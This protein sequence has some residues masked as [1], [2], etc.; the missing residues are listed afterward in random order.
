MSAF[1]AAYS[2]NAIGKKLCYRRSQAA[3][4]AGN[5]LFINLFANSLWLRYCAV[6]IL[7]SKYSMWS[8]DSTDFQNKKGA[9]IFNVGWAATIHQCLILQWKIYQPHIPYNVYKESS[10]PGRSLFQGIE[11]RNKA[12]AFAKMLISF[13]Q[14]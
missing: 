13:F 9:E 1:A 12:I 8:M 7:F 6:Y 5:L 10:F 2:Q 11:A 14:R 4:W 3:W